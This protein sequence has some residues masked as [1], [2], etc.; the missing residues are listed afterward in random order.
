MGSKSGSMS[1][2]SANESTVVDF[3][4]VNFAYK[5]EKGESLKVLDQLTV[6]IRSSEFFGFIG[7]SGC[8][9]TTILRLATDL[10]DSRQCDYCTGAISVLNSSPGEARSQRKF[11][12]LFQDSILFPW[13]NVIENVMLPSEII[14]S[15]NKT[16]YKYAE[17]L[18]EVVGLKQFMETSVSAL[19]GG[20]Q[21]RVS[22]VRALMTSP[23]ILLFD[24]PFASLDYLV[25][26]QLMQLLQRLWTETK[27]TVI[28]VSHDLPDV[29]MLCDRI[30]VLSAR[31]ASIIDIIEVPIPRPRA[32]G[33]QLEK[34]YHE[35]LKRVR[36]AL[37]SISA[38][39]K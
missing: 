26:E 23:S 4:N 1:N 6:S 9:K 8:G 38:G 34:E 29:V 19:S 14:G 39:E 32:F 3:Q 25:R 10:I 16:Q 20:M 27:P 30:A 18:L 31:P 22:L 28:F 21:Q 15:P 5:T 36:D 7:P 37:R 2:T 33:R 11:G 12:F 17:E 35:S 13:R 24:E